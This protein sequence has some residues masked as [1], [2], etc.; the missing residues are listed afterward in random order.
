MTVP[1]LWCLT[2]ISQDGLAACG[3][4]L[5]LLGGGVQVQQHFGTQDRGNHRKTCCA[6]VAGGQ[7]AEPFDFL[8]GCLTANIS[9]LCLSFLP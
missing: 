6:P 9:L 8:S 2:L 1:L 3:S 7:G 4:L 5:H